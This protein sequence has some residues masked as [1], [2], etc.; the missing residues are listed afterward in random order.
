MGDLGETPIL[1]PAFEERARRWL[2][3]C[4]SRSVDEFV[5]D[6]RDGAFR[7]QRIVGR[8]PFQIDIDKLGPLSGFREPVWG[9]DKEIYFDRGTD[10]HGN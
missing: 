6:L 2:H 1:H 9:S 8:N 5:V 4:A 3:T 10:A 7:V